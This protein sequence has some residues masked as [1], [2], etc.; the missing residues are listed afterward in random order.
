[1]HVEID[2]VLAEAVE[3]K[4]VNVRKCNRILVGMELF[5]RTSRLCNHLLSNLW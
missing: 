5:P 4:E 1:M 2:L 3:E